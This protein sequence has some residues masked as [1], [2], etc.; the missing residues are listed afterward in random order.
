MMSVYRRREEKSKK[1]RAQNYQKEKNGIRKSISG[2]INKSILRVLIP[3]LILLIVISCI[4]AARSIN[5]LNNSVL[6]AQTNNAINIVES[7]FENKVTAVSM[8]QF[9]ARAQR[10]FEGTPTAE[11]IETYKDKED[12]VKLLSDTKT[13]MEEKGVQAVWF[14][15]TDNSAYLMSTGEISP[16][17][18]SSVAWDESIRNTKETAISEPF[19]DSVSGK[20][21]ISIVAPVFSTVNPEEITGFAG[22]D[23]FE[24][25]L[26]ER[27]S[28][29]KIGEGGF[30]E[31]L[32]SDNRYIYSIDAQ[33]IDNNINDIE[34]LD[35][36][37]REHVLNSITGD[38][39]YSY[40]GVKYRGF[41]E[42][43]GINNWGAIGNLPVK[44]LNVTRNQL[45]FIL[46]V[47]AVIILI[48]LVASIQRAIT[49]VTKPI[50]VLTE[51]VER[52][53][54]GDLSVTI[55]VHTD[56]EIGILAES[57]KETIHSLQGIINNISYILT[58]ISGGNLRIT[59]EGDYI[60]DFQPIKES[61]VK[62]TDALNFT[63]GQINES[64]SQVSL[65]STQLAGSAQSL[66]E[67]ATEQAGSVQ[68]LQATI[69]EVAGQ[70][71]ETAK[72]GREAYNKAQEVEEEA[73]ISS[74]EM[75]KMVSAMERITETSNQ[76]AGI[77]SEIEDIASQTNLLSLNAAIEA[78]R[79]GEAGK[80]FAVVAEQIRKLA[81]DSAK[82]A[83][84]TK[85]LIETSLKEVEIGS[86]ITVETAKSL[87]RVI[88]GLELIAQRVQKS[89]EASD[90]QKE[91]IGQIAEGI[92][93]ISSVVQGNSAV[94]EETSATSE[95]LSAQATTLNELVG[96]FELRK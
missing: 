81:E 10:Y 50:Y 23:V 35:K 91:T 29:I 57:V 49:K 69:T 16:F 36:T 82:S 47:L 59:I 78:A 6:K 83:V 80:G 38:I 22:M 73:Q 21:V 66:A 7:F 45:I 33:I 88:S 24:E 4:M 20:T 14:A 25:A 8:F 12:V 65:G 43:C 15:G 58:E 86:N 42:A 34:G 9:N 2:K 46:G 90:T 27:L 63:L 94:A 18:Y 76:I 64:S 68:E 17:D 56:D 13:L 85:N 31:I 51:G 87:K 19:L 92:E 74:G 41:I 71:R 75:K 44:E 1:M 62:I 40:N 11:D 48:I 61:L 53:S 72:L 67:G 96:K 3:A 95:E 5:K 37:Y 32:S 89:S 70:T 55:D 79:A 54:K 26:A 93:Q 52:F 77:I 60:G 30:L 84:N 28:D 39:D